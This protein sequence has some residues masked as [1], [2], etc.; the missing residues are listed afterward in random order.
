MT[1]KQAFEALSKLPFDF[2]IGGSLGL[3]MFGIINREIKDIDIVVPSLDIDYFTDKPKEEG[4]GE[5]VVVIRDGDVKIEVYEGNEDF[6][7]IQD[8]KVSLPNYAIEAK[9]RYVQECKALI[10]KSLPCLMTP[11]IEARMNKH[12]NDIDL[13]EDWR[14]GG[15]QLQKA[16]DD[17]FAKMID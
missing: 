5:D 6:V 13:Y 8:L 15:L 11:I 9:K 3:K 2:Q 12:Q 1:D 14:N 4:S 16:I 7:L 10:E 17:P